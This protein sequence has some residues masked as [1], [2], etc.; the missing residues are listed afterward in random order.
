MTPSTSASFKP[1]KKLALFVCPD[2]I[3]RIA[4]SVTPTA[5]ASALGVICRR[6]RK[7]RKR[8]PKLPDTPGS[9]LRRSRSVVLRDARKCAT[10]T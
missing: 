3:W 1:I 5:W 7:V 4:P 6:V 9:I 10:G 2:S 8:S